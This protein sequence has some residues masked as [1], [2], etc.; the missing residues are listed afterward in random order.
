MQNRSFALR[1]RQR[2]L[3]AVLTALL[4]TAALPRGPGAHKRGE[5]PANPPPI[6]GVL[7]DWNSGLQSVYVPVRLEEKL[8]RFRWTLKDGGVPVCFDS[9]RRYRDQAP[10]RK[11]Y[12]E[13]ACF[14]QIVIGM[15]RGTW[16]GDEFE[17]DAPNQRGGAVLHF[18]DGA[19]RALPVANEQRDAWEA[20]RL[21]AVWDGRGSDEFAFHQLFDPEDLAPV[22]LE[23]IS[24][25]RGGE[26]VPSVAYDQRQ[27]LYSLTYPRVVDGSPDLYTTR[28]ETIEEYEEGRREA[29]ESIIAM[30]RRE[31]RTRGGRWPGGFARDEVRQRILIAY[32]EILRA[33]ISPRTPSEDGM[34]ETIPH[35]WAIGSDGKPLV[36]PWPQYEKWYLTEVESRTL[37]L[38]GGTDPEQLPADTRLLAEWRLHLD[39][40]KLWSE[41]KKEPSST[42]RSHIFGA[43]AALAR[44]QGARGSAELAGQIATEW[45]LAS[46]LSESA[47]AGASRSAASPA[48][49]SP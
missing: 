33:R 41:E 27:R 28:F 13:Y 14:P 24:G 22:M 21:K 30:L 3:T 17:G 15:Y 5:R 8:G 32:D 43:M 45:E 10:E 6:V 19:V 36:L 37:A 38:D 42:E 34:V 40:F 16:E 9:W 23:S 26:G 44:F 35:G 31:A 1:R 2:R 20:A 12:Y 47:S 49:V 46:G 4:F 29:I 48:P 25:R 18:Q 7:R 11:P 39:L